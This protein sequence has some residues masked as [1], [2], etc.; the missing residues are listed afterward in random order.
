M[1]GKVIAAQPALLEVPGRRPWC[2]ILCDWAFLILSV[3]IGP[4][5]AYIPMYTNADAALEA[6]GRLR[7]NLSVCLVLPACP[8]EEGDWAKLES[9]HGTP[10]KSFRPGSFVWNEF[11]LLYPRCER[12]P[13]L[14]NLATSKIKL[15]ASRR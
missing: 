15:L 11:F 9:P 1:R 14:G 6:G 10:V 12:T 4:V 8:R 13:R 2:Q 5:F 3:S 7:G